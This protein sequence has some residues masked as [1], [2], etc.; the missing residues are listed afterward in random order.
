MPWWSG[1]IVLIIFV[2][3]KALLLSLFSTYQKPVDMRVL[4]SMSD[5]SHTMLPVIIIQEILHTAMRVIVL[6]IAYFI[7][8]YF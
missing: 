4:E 6:T 2:F 3:A 1:W 8:L 5:E 7:F